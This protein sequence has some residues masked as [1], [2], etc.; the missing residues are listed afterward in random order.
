MIST[1]AIVPAF[2]EQHTI[3]HTVR[4]LY[5]I[6]K[7]NQVVV[8]DDGSTDQTGLRAFQA[9]A[10]VLRLHTNRGKTAA[11]CYGIQHTEQDILLFVDADLGK[12]AIHTIHLV[13]PVMRGHVD[14]TIAAWPTAGREGGFGMVKNV[15]HWLI[16]QY[17]GHHIYNPLSGQRALRRDMWRHWQ[18]GVGFGFEV[19]LT[20]DMLQAGKRIAEIPLPLAHRSLGRSLNGFIHRG[21]QLMHITRT[22]VGRR[23]TK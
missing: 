19:A 8:I 23:H 9:G 16:K 5:S 10:R 21:R 11:L 3:Q 12:T 17:T 6:P 22:V 20:L 2:N 13:T 4:A 14:M 18:G 15:S 7:I 1:V